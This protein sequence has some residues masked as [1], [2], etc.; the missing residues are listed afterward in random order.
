[1]NVLKGVRYIKDRFIAHKTQ[2]IRE[3]RRLHQW[4][5][6]ITLRHDKV[7]KERRS[8]KHQ[9]RSLRRS[10]GEYADKQEKEDELRQRLREL[11]WELNEL[12]FQTHLTS[13]GLKN[14]DFR[15]YYRHISRSRVGIIVVNLVLWFLI[16]R[17]GGLGTGLKIVVMAYAVITT[18]GGLFEMGLLLRIRER[19]LRPIDNLKQ[20]VD[21]IVRGNYSVVVE[22]AQTNEIAPLIEA[23]NGMAQKLNKIEKLKAEYEGNRKSLIA[24]IS[25]DLKTPITAVQ[26]YIEAIIEQDDMPRERLKKYLTIIHNNTHYINRL[27]DDLFLFSKLDMQKLELCLERVS[28]KP[29]M[30]DLMEEF[31]LDLAERG[32]DFTYQDELENEQSLEL[33]SKRFHQIIRNVLDNAVKYGLDKPLKIQARLSGT[34]EKILLELRDNGPGIPE[35]SIARV[36]ERFYRVDAERTKD[37]ASTGLGLAI[38][39]E[40]VRAHG[41]D[42]RVS[43]ALNEGTVFIIKLPIIKEEEEKPKDQTREEGV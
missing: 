23:F 34:D 1:M 43:S 12:H 10:R 24:N 5:T 22:N 11:E 41:G 16:V 30:A 42:I 25:H 13:G 8:V 9:L 21:E 40:L 26:G 17:F 36:F 27:I 32:V 2:E 20:G 39:K 33:D 31:S 28:I 15:H 6:E 7:Q 18:L 38:A 37:F 19:I 14:G 35:E 4:H 3:M 29:F